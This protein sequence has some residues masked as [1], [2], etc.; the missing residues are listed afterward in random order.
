MRVTQPRLI[1][2]INDK[3]LDGFSY[4]LPVGLLIGLGLIIF[5]I[6]SR[7]WK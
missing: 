4:F 7:L 2:R 6:V 5:G 1:D 3:I